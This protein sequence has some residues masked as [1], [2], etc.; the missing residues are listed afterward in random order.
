MQP[1]YEMRENVILENNGQK[2]FGVFHRPVNQTNFPAILICHG[3]GGHKV[4]RYRI[5]VTLSSRLA[6]LGIGSLRI[7]FRGSGDSEG[8]FSEMTIEGE[9]SDALVAL[10]FLRQQPGVDLHRIGIFGRSLGG[11]VA[12]LTASSDRKIKTMGLWAPIFNSKQWVEKWNQLHSTPLDLSSKQEFMTVDG[13]IP[14]YEF[15]QQFFA[16]KTEESVA[17]LNG[18]P[19]LLIHGT[20]D[21]VVTLDHTEQYLQV[22]LKGKGETK[23]I[24]LPHC[25][26]DFTHMEER[27]V[28]LD[29]TCRWFQQSL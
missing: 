4:G 25:D 22:R 14:G 6:Q 18:L 21:N 17:S 27:R 5:Y 3:L 2:I 16:L 23:F 15:Y 28:A 11:L 12:V 1:P 24:E 29:E 20:M 13:Q 10:D 7:D 8:D 26:H 9:V 19:L